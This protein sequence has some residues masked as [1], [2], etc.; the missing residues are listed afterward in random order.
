MIYLNSQG[1]LIIGNRIPLEISHYSQ[2]YSKL[3]SYMLACKKLE[4][5]ASNFSRKTLREK[6]KQKQEK[7]K[8]NGREKESR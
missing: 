7:Y 2:L 3:I 1:M 4:T 6:R 8:G 5:Q